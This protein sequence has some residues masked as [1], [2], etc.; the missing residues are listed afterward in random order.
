MNSSDTCSLWTLNHEL[1]GP[2]KSGENSGPLTL[3]PPKANPVRTGLPMR[4]D[5]VTD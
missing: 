3:L 2:R 5:V 4:H 1:C